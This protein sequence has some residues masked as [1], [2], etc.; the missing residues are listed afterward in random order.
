MV[1]AAS[2]KEDVG[3]MSSQ[4]GVGTDANTINDH[5]VLFDDCLGNH[6]TSSGEKSQKEEKAT[7]RL[8][9]SSNMEQVA[10]IIFFVHK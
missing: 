6:A 8:V 7:P 10:T 9:Y 3:K 4:Y 5:L 2:W 1:I